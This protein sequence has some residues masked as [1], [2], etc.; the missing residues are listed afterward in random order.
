MARISVLARWLASAAGALLLAVAPAPAMA[1]NAWAD[2]GTTGGGVLTL[3]WDGPG[4]SLDWRGREAPIA[5]EGT[6]VG[7]HILVP[8]DR[9]TRT[10]TVTN[11]GPGAGIATVS[12]LD[13]T[14]TGPTD[15]AGPSLA[16]LIELTWSIDGV[17][18]STTWSRAAATPVAHA[19]QVDLAKGASF[20]LTVGAVFPA[21]ATEGKNPGGAATAQVLTYKVRVDMQEDTRTG[22]DGPLGGAVEGTAPTRLLLL[23][24][25]AGAAGAWLLG[26]RPTQASTASGQAQPARAGSGA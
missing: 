1:A 25:A 4:T 15:Q 14:I 7:D 17:P 24:L 26:R 3:V 8:G 10:A 19:T 5:A 9:I 22:P 2:D 12:I 11:N 13:V 18:G 16:D 20:R 6:F 21:S 23:G